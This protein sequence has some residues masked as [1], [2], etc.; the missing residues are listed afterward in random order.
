MQT[1]ET[2]Q[3]GRKALD[4][5]DEL[6]LHRDALGELDVR[7]VV[8]TPEAARSVYAMETSTGAEPPPTEETP[9]EGEQICVYGVMPPFGNPTDHEIA[10]VLTY[11]RS[12]F[13]NSGAPIEDSDVAL[14]GCAHFWRARTQVTRFPMISAWTTCGSQ[15]SE[16]A[17]PSRGGRGS[18]FARSPMH[19]MPTL[20]DP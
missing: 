17:R 18:Q 15:D 19:S 8:R 3:G 4:G 13:G 14:Q 1:A 16:L 20:E 5:D 11:V 12:H 7:E 9:P 10:N 2:Y 6:S